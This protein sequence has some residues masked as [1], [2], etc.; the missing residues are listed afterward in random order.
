MRTRFFFSLSISLICP[1]RLFHPLPISLPSCFLSYYT[2]SPPHIPIRTSQLVG[3]ENVASSSSPETRNGAIKVETPRFRRRAMRDAPG[4]KKGKNARL[5]FPSSPSSQ[6][7]TCPRTQY[8]KKLLFPAAGTP[9][10]Q[11]VVSFVRGEAKR[12]KDGEGESGDFDARLPLA[13]EQFEAPPSFPSTRFLF[14]LLPLSLPRRRPNS[15]SGMGCTYVLL[16]TQFMKSTSRYINF[17]A[18]RMRILSVLC[19]V[20]FVT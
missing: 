5:P 16:G 12:G 8:S 11:T 9:F 14:S 1:F 10:L 17:P 3:G 19:T 13:E 4:Q 7:P 20:R 6:L 15:L 18:V 2:H